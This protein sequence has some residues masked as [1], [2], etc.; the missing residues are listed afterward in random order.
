MRQRCTSFG[1]LLVLIVSLM[2]TSAVASTPTLEGITERIKLN[3]QISGEFVQLKYLSI[4]PNPLRSSGNFSFMPDSGL[5]WETLQPLHSRLTFSSK[6]ISQEQNGQQVWLAQSDQPGVAVIG[7]ILAAMF[8]NDWQTLK[9]FFSITV[10]PDTNAH[11]WHLELIPSQA[12]LA[13]AMERIELTGDRQ[14]QRITLYE[15]SG[16]RTEIEFTPKPATLQP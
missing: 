6:G 3:E 15:H 4:L 11:Q 8:T 5:F 14:L 1:Y 10:K 16:D 2:S 13:S 9:D 7:K 12:T